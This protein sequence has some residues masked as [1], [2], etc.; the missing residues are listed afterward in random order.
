MSGERFWKKSWDPGM[1]DLDPERFE[2]SYPDAI[3]DVIGEHEVHFDHI[4]IEIFGKL[5]W[6]IELFERVYAPLDINVVHEHIFP[7]MQVQACCMLSTR[8]TRFMQP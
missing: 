1:A 5:E 4:G 3:R 2:T 8:C 7:S 6:Y